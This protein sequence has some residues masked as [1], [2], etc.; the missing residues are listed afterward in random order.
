M[1]RTLGAIALVASLS[2]GCAPA[3]QDFYVKPDVTL[4]RY[5]RDALACVNQATAATPTNTQIGW[6]PYV[7]LYSADTNA[8]LRAANVQ[9][10]MRDRG[11]QLVQFPACQTNIPEAQRFGFGDRTRLGQRLKVGPQS[12]VTWGAQGE[13]IL[14]TPG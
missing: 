5:E 9:L 6:M 8:G 14:Y 7:G 12:C 2:A 13:T 1:L 11:Y 10:C 4:D 3:R